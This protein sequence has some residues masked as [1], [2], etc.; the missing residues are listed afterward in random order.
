MKLTVSLATLLALSALAAAPLAAQDPFAA[1][2][3]NSPLKASVSIDVN[4]GADGAWMQVTPGVG[5][6]FTPRWS[7]EAG[8]PLYY[9][10]AAATYG[11][12]AALG[13][14]GDVYGSLSLDLSTDALT[15]YTTLTASAPTGNADK[16]LGSGQL[17]WDGTAHLAGEVGRFGPYTTAGLGNNIKAASETL[18]GGAG[19]ARPATTS[20]NGN[21][22]HVDTGLEFTVWKSLT[23]TASGYGVFAFNRP[24]VVTPVTPRPQPG[25]NGPRRNLRRPGTP[26]GA[27]Q[28]TPA[29]AQDDG[30]DH[31]VGLVLWDQV[32]PWLDLSLWFSHSL[33]YDNYRTVSVSATFNLNH[34]GASRHRQP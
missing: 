25:I 34:R 15:A 18:G 20:T 5:Y 4:T 12:I 32:T 1:Q 21:L 19:R 13:G 29:T 31:G 11:G 22:A 26:S 8:V 10:S 3:P 6:T 28:A 14:V 16:G 9:V 24:R 2:V 17:S 7:V 23:L 27:R 30:S 33:A